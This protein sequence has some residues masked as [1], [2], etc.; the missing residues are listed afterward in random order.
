MSA[1]FCLGCSIGYCFYNVILVSFA[2]LQIFAWPRGGGG[3]PT[4]ESRVSLNWE[5]P[6]ALGLPRT[7]VSSDSHVL[8]LVCAGVHAI[9]SNVYGRRLVHTR[10]FQSLTPTTLF[11]LGFTYPPAR[12]RRITAESLEK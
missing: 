11:S 2:S 7:A 9:H 3:V 8:G 12:R 4:F 5:S 1:L 10:S 6:S